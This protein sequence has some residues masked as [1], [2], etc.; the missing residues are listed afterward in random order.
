MKI[1]YPTIRYGRRTLEN[2]DDYYDV[3]S[4][5]PDFPDDVEELFRKRVCQNLE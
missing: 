3:L 5:S 1:E 4:K 2:N